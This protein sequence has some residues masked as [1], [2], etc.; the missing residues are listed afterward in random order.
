MSEFAYGR[1]LL[2]FARLAAGFATVATLWLAFAPSGAGP[3]LIPWDKAGH[4]LSF[5]VLTLLYALALPRVPRWALA[6]ALV[7]AGGGIEIVQGFVGREPDWKDWIAD[8]AGIAAVLI[9]MGVDRLL[10]RDAAGR[11]GSVAR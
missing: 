4:F 8:M 1:S 2:W 9:P 5:Y 10:R 11:D 6:A 7:L 3:G